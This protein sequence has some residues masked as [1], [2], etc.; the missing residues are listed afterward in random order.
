MRV[1]QPAWT[2]RVAD[3][4]KLGVCPPS[5]GLDCADATSSKTP[6]ED[7]AARLASAESLGSRPLAGKRVAV[8]R[9]MMGAGVDAGVDAAVRRAMA[10]LES[11]GATLEEVSTAE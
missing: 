5:S 2:L 1:I 3:G 4:L 7:F 6:T 8:L 11:L 10:H 9:E